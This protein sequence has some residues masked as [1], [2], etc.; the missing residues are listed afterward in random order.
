[1]NL[2]IFRR[3]PVLD[4]F[5]R[6]REE[7]NRMVGRYIG[8]SGGQF[9]AGLP[10]I[11]GWIPPIDVSETDEEIVIRGE[12]PGI[13][14]RDLEITITGTTLSI[15]GKKEE[16][17]E[18][19]QEDFYRSERR[20]GAFR[21]VLDLPEAADTERVTADSDNGVI[22]IRVAKKPGQRAKRIEVKPTSRRVP[23]PG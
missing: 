14:A 4:E 19:E 8:E 10:R 5:A 6:M 12:M 9:D 16:K 11:E 17:E 3:T 22:T 13:A 23:V 7:M 15:A 1:M 21:R 20:F 2:S 18:M